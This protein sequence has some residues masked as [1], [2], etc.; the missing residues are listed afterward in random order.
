MSGLIWGLDIKI[1]TSSRLSKGLAK[2]P[3]CLAHPEREPWLVD[4]FKWKVCKMQWLYVVSTPNQVNLRLWQRLPFKFL[5]VQCKPR[6]E[7]LGKKTTKKQSETEP[8]LL[9]RFSTTNLDLCSFNIIL[10]WRETEQSLHWHICPNNT[11]GF[12]STVKIAGVLI[13]HAEVKVSFPPDELG[14]QRTEL[15]GESPKP[16][17]EQTKRLDIILRASLPKILLLT[18][19]A[20]NTEGKGRMILRIL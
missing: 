11:L 12:C 6:G 4:L 2:F 20:R 5:A 3:G 17:K 18:K 16:T 13:T 14:N 19:E 1:T 10:L 7:C 15:K 8:I 9:N